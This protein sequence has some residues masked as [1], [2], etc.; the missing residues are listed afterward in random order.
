MQLKRYVLSLMAE[1]FRQS[2]HGRMECAWEDEVCILI[3]G[4]HVVKSRLRS[5]IPAAFA[6]VSRD[7]ST[8]VFSALTGTKPK[9]KTFL[10]PLL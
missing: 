1:V 6:F 10:L 4:S 7:S 8:T 3:K 5:L 9:A 2:V